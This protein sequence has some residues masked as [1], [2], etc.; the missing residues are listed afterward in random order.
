MLPIPIS[1]LSRTFIELFYGTQTNYGRFLKFFHGGKKIC[2]MASPL[3][4]LTADKN[5]RKMFVLNALFSALLP[6][7]NSALS[8]KCKKKNS[9][10]QKENTKTAFQFCLLPPPTIFFSLPIVIELEASLPCTCAVISHFYPSP[11]Y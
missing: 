11:Y 7:F 6:A 3:L 5:W 8:R 10:S 2:F 1:D 9:D 4:F